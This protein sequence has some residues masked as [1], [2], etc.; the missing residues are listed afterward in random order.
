[1]EANV[2]IF[3][4]LLSTLIA[5]IRKQNNAFDKHSLITWQTKQIPVLLNIQGKRKVT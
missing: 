5:E 4:V 1:M 3:T 2:Q